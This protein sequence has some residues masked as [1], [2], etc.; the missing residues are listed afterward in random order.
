[1]EVFQLLLLEFEFNVQVLSIA[2]TAYGELSRTVSQSPAPPCPPQVLALSF[3]LPS[4]LT[5]LF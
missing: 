5:L 3:P 2:F 4:A 1:M